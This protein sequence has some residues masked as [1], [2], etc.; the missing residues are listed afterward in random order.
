MTQTNKMK[1]IKIKT[2]KDLRNHLSGL[3]YGIANAMIKEHGFYT[4][5]YKGEKIKFV[6]A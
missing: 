4:C 6:V 1:T 5:I 2:N 3:A